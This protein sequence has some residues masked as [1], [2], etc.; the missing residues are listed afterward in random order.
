[1]HNLAI[2]LKLKNEYIIT[3]SDD[4]VFEP[5]KSRLAKHDLLP[6]EMGWFPEKITEDI[7]AIILGMHARADNPELLKAKE[8][9][10]K[11]F[12][13][14]EYLYEQSKDKTRVVIG[15]S[16]GK[17]SITAMI[18]HVLQSYKMNIDYM[19]GAQLTGFDTMVKITSDS[20]VMVLEGD[21]YLSSPID[22]RPKFHLYKGHIAII[23][24]IAWDHINVFPTFENY[25]EQ[26][27]IFVDTLEPNATLIYCEK[28]EVLKNLVEN[29]QRTDIRRIPYSSHASETENGVTS[30]I[31]D[32]NE[33]ELMIFGD[34]NMQ[35]L[36]AA[37]QACLSLGLSK[38]DFYSA[39]KSFKGAAKRLELIAINENTR[40]YKDFAHSPS[41][42]KATTQAVKSQFK[43]KKLIACM[44]L[45]TFSSLNKDFLNEYEG[46][47][48][49]ADI[50]IVYY[51]HHTIEHKRLENISESQVKEAFKRDDLIIF[52][53]SKELQNYLKAQNY[54]DYNLL[55][56][57][58]GNYDG[59]DVDN[60]AKELLISG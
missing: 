12:S 28:D 51:N 1:M 60:F 45:H 41:K 34:H 11:I 50:A 53:D 10:L 40:V 44:E 47:M 3:G 30:L 26:F 23:S 25:V 2:A 56:M 19:V 6:A 15:G 7:E 5:S 18:L 21:E 32:G 4:E 24:G 13:Y 39:I 42:L 8:L 46:A 29:H 55:L 16:H 27:S 36:Q 54:D 14:P 48:D 9:N 33:Y 49:V 38:E 35:N 58:S 52:T 17:T 57:S 31:D 22:R 20:K 59:I 37:L 43:N